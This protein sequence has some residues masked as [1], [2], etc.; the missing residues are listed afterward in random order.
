MPVVEIELPDIENIEDAIFPGGIDF[1]ISAEKAAIL[2]KNP[3]AIIAPNEAGYG[4]IYLL[5]WKTD[6]WYRVMYNESSGSEMT[7]NIQTLK[8]HGKNMRMSILLKAINVVK[9]VSNE[10]S[11][12]PPTAYKVPTIKAVYDEINKTK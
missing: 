1:E 4:C 11:D 6:E 5:P 9:F 3:C 12:F 7:S 2:D 8:R 10:E